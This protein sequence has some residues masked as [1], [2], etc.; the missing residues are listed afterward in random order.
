[1]VTVIDYEIGN[2]R[3]L[4]KALEH[5]GAK[6]HRTD[7]PDDIAAATQLVLPGVGAF[8]ACIGEIRRRGLEQ[9][10]VAAI[11]RGTPF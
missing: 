5:I 6:V 1:M 9:P 4:E 3:S 8:G 2:M 10:I 7:H 11:N